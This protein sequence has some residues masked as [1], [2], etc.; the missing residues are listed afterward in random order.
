MVDIDQHDMSVNLPSDVI[1]R[2]NQETILSALADWASIR[3]G[4]TCPP[5]VKFHV[6]EVSGEIQLDILNK[7]FSR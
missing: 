6:D 4:Y 3:Y 7:P 2:V 1:Q 5:D